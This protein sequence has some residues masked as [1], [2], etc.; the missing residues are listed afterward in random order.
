MA[1][2]WLQIPNLVKDET[3]MVFVTLHEGLPPPRPSCPFAINATDDALNVGM[4]IK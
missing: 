1:T 2:I 3:G 4:V